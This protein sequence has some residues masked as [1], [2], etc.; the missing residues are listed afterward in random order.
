M[1]FEL[2]STSF[3]GACRRTRAVLERVAA[4]IPDAAVRE[5]DVAAAPERAATLGIR[6]TPTVVVRS[7]S[8]AD[9][10]RAEGVPT[11]DHVLV[12]AARAREEA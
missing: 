4:L 1:E 9:I 3:C 5:F 7:G 11:I 6:A 10:L 8:G 12:A 2:Y